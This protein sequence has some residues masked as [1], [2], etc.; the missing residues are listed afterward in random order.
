[1]SISSKPFASQSLSKEITPEVRLRQAFYRARQA[2]ANVPQAQ[3][4]QSDCRRDLPT[5]FASRLA[6][7]PFHFEIAARPFSMLQFER[8]SLQ[9]GEL[10]DS[11]R[12]ALVVDHRA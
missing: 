2:L 4:T 8:A 5:G 6:R 11:N 7:I 12:P 9:P 10:L 3:T 1:M